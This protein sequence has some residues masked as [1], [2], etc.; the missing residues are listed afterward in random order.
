MF[1]LEFL[2][3]SLLYALPLAGLPILLHM[4]FRRKAPVIWFSTLRFVKASLQHTAA[5][6]RIQRWLLLA[7]RVLLL[8]LL[9]W[10]IAQPVRIL[11]SSW[12]PGKSTIAAIVIDTSYSMQ[13]EDNQVKLLA[14]AD[15]QAQ[16]LLRGLLRDAKV[17]VLTSA[18][19]ADG[20]PPL[21]R[22]ATQVL[23]EWTPLSP[24]PALRPLSERVAQAI[25]LLA[26]Q[27]ADQKWLVIISDLQNREF[28]SPLPAFAE[29]ADGA[30]ARRLLLLDLHPDEARSA[31]VTGVRLEPQ[32]SIPGV[33]SRVVVEVTARGGDARAVM[34][35]IANLQ[36]QPLNNKPTLMAAFDTTGKTQVRFE[37]KTGLPIPGA[38]EGKPGRWLLVEGALQAEDAM[39]WDNSRQLLVEIP[40]RQNV[41]IVG[42][43]KHPGAE[44]FLRLA[45]DP[46]EGKL[47]SWPL[48]MRMGAD[49]IATD[50]VAVVMLGRWPESAQLQRW[51]S[52]VQ[53]GGSLVLFVQP[54]LE[55]QY[56]PLS[57]EQKK[58]LAELLPSQP[59]AGRR[60][61]IVYRAT[62]GSMTDALLEGLTDPA[63]QLGAMTVRRLVPFAPVTNS[64]SRVVLGAAPATAAG[65][66]RISGLWFGRKVGAGQVYT[67]ATLPD[68]LYTSMPLHPLFMPILVR[69]CLRTAGLGDVQNVEIGHSISLGL[70]GKGSA[71]GLQ[72]IDPKGAKYQYQPGQGGAF[73][74]DPASM[75]LSYSQAS[76][77]GLYLWQ[78]ENQVLGMSNVQLPAAESELIY[79]PAE[80][81]APSGPNTIIARSGQ[82]LQAQLARLNEPEPRWTL[83]IALVLLLL[84]AEALLGNI[85]QL[86]KPLWT[87]W[88]WRK[89]A[90]ESAV[91][92]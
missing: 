81:V 7:C 88:P 65:G 71:S 33:G 1:G 44:A 35:N 47:S 36:Q 80:S 29:T 70:A 6:R 87:G 73:E 77:P 38:A 54:G 89:T 13:L 19:P 21:L 56:A 82:Q 41:V 25:D 8:V 27:Q 51:M 48:S 5:R 18:P 85:S 14:K 75:R 16:D 53:G 50:H 76:L 15:E 86:W 4:L 62:P 83:P 90:E 59:L 9:I 3:G 55:E 12:A 46:W 45:L 69:A 31:G 68:A 52:F 32:Q 11:A 10:A 2:F 63:L 64:Q 22:V 78:R 66:A 61:S 79:R 84:C 43:G 30:S 92:V 39:A 67:I 26:R 23:A 57:A 42:D 49:P 24:Q 40:P 60:A 20:S 91:A 34:L 74:W 72:L 58:L 17:A 37:L 28:A